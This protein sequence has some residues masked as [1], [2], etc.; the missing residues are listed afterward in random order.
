MD[1]LTE[2]LEIVHHGLEILEGLSACLWHF[3][4]VGEGSEGVAGCRWGSQGQGIPVCFPLKMSK[5]VAEE[6]RVTGD[7]SKPRTLG[8]HRR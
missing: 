7:L 2:Y 3:L 8:S 1:P 5:T 6:M 4:L